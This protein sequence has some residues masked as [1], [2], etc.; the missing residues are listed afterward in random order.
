MALADFLKKNEAKLK[1]ED[2]EK[3]E[4]SYR[5]QLTESMK[6]IYLDD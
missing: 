2:I 5:V 1:I 6:G 4:K 3:F